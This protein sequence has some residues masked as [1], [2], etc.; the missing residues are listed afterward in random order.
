MS[1]KEFKYD[2]PEGFIKELGCTVRACIDC[3]CL[4]SGGPTRCTRC[5]EQSKLNWFQKVLYNIIGI[6]YPNP[7]KEREEK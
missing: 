6:W 3:G 7:Q 4:V 5:A 1:E 2:L